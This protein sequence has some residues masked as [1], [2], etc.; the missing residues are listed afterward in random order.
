MQVLRPATLRSPR[1]GERTEEVIS[2]V[3]INS[4]RYFPE[5]DVFRCLW[6]M[7][8]LIT[9]LNLLKKHCWK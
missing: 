8:F 5:P 7:L 9:V 2:N 3:L 1:T 6:K 4:Y